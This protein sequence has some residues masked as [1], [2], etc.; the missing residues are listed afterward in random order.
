MELT[1]NQQTL[2]D[3]IANLRTNLRA[4]YDAL[5]EAYADPGQHNVAAAIQ[6]ADIANQALVDAVVRAMNA[7][8]PADMLR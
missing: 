6:A 5:D 7:G 4:A 1:N 3:G 2:L 8:V